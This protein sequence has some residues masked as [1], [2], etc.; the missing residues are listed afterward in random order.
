MPK[1]TLVSILAS[2]LLLSSFAITGETYIDY[3][4]KNI[5]N[6]LI[7]VWQDSSH[8]PLKNFNRVKEFVAKN[9][10][11]LVFATNG[12]MYNASS[13]P[14]GLY[15][16]KGNTLTRLNTNNGE[17]N[18][19]LMP[20][21]VFYITQKNKAKIVTTPK[22]DVAA[23]KEAK[24]ATQ[25]GP[26]L[27]INGEVHS[28]F[29]KDSKNLN[30]RSGVGVLPGGGVVFSMSENPVNFYQFAMHFKKMGCK[31]ALYLDGFVSKMYYPEK[32]LQGSNNDVFGVI[33]AVVK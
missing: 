24:Y 16:E 1:V 28:A 20:N 18:F 13:A 6:N 32:N 4:V 29:N 15:I 19:H 14:V 10:K 3:E 9:N 5:D 27:L 30:I 26:M 2:F 23:I 8:K 33:I 11:Q 21:G 17:G 7:M 22:M 31:N 12:G 25:S